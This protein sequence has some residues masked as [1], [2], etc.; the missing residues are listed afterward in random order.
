MRPLARLLGTRLAG[1]AW[2]LAAEA[3]WHLLGAAWAFA[4]LTAAI[5]WLAA[6]L[7]AAMA[8]AAAATAKAAAVENRVDALV[9]A[10]NDAKDAAATAQSTANNA[11]P[12]SGGS[13]SGDLTVG[14]Y[15]NVGKSVNVDWHVICQ[16]NGDFFGNLGCHTYLWAAS[17]T[18]NA[19]M[20]G[21]GGDKDTDTRMGDVSGTYVTIN[22]GNAIIHRV[23]NLM[24]W[25]D[26]LCDDVSY[27]IGRVNA[28][29][30]ALG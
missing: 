15:L 4:V 17:T 19:I 3:A 14:G 25:H 12:R 27:L 30:Y 6:R 2:A 5:G 22:A 11:L 18:G 20:G 23:N 8:T 29:T 28:F 1:P 26:A 9:P 24:D 7:P 16:G 13:V 10:V 21:V